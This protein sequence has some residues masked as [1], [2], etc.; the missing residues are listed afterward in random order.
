MEAKFTK[1]P[2]KAD[3]LDCTDER[4]FIL[5]VTCVKTGDVVANMTP[6]SLGW[7][8]NNRDM[9]IEANAR[10]IA[11]A[12]C[13]YEALKGLRA[14]TV[15]MTGWE[16]LC[17]EGVDGSCALCIADAALAKAEGR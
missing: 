3:K 6:T 1:G 5:S 15:E 11:A 7:P 13:L 2:W 14:Y 12:P 8:K 17:D 16:C 9:E 10:L 4:S